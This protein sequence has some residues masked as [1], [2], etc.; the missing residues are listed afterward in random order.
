MGRGGGGCSSST[1]AAAASG[2]PRGFPAAAAA[3]AVV[4][5]A[6]AKGGDA[7]GAALAL[8]V[9]LLLGLAFPGL[10]Q[11]TTCLKDKEISF[12]SRK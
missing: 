3:A 12:Y 5:V 10:E 11:T 6:A 8:P 1:A 7:V 4:C 2:A 9:P